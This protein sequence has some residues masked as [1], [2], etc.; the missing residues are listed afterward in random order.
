ME[1]YM[2][3]C[4]CVLGGGGGVTKALVVSFSVGYISDFANIL[5]TFFES[6]SYSSGVTAVKPVKHERDI[7]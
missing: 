7:Q 2:C 6:H 4:V 3:V 5:I 1:W